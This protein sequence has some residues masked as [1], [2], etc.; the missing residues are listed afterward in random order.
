M[1]QLKKMYLGEKIHCKLSDKMVEINEENSELLLLNGHAHL[2]V[3]GEKKVT[4]SETKKEESKNPKIASAGT[5]PDTLIG[6][7][8]SRIEFLKSASEGFRANP[9]LTKKEVMTILEANSVD[10]PSDATMAIL[11]EISR[12]KL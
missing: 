6:T 10:F 9:K 4:K 11:A 1:S 7:T 2:F 5:S 12:E 3:D 8:Y